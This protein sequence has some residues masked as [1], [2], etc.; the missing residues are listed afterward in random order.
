MVILMTLVGGM[1]TMAG[2]IVG[3]VVILFLENKLGD[4][5]NWLSVTTHIDWFST[6]GESVSLVTGFIFIACVLMF[7]RGIVGEVVARARPP[8]VDGPF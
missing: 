3:A 4:F 8:L 7:R 6:L 1:E 2:P 5:G